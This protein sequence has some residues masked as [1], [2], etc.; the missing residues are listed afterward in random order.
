MARMNLQ[1]H[2]VLV[3]LMNKVRRCWRTLCA[4][5]ARCSVAG[6]LSRLALRMA[7]VFVDSHVVR[8]RQQFA[9]LTDHKPVGRRWV[10]KEQ[11]IRFFMMCYKMLNPQSDMT[12]QEQREALE[13]PCGCQCVGVAVRL[14][15]DAEAGCHASPVWLRP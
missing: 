7:G 9:V 12:L 10:T 15:T 3:E 2:P 14:L 6:R 5:R 8:S 4:C 11:Y 1:R 13:V